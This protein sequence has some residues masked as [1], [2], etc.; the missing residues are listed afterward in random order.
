MFAKRALRPLYLATALTAAVIAAGCSH[1]PQVQEPQRASSLSDAQEQAR[2][3]RDRGQANSQWSFGLGKNKTAESAPE[4]TVPAG[5]IREL[6]EARTFLGTIACPPSDSACM[7]VR[8]LTTMSP[9][10]VWR[11]RASAANTNAEPVISQGCW[12]Q[13]GTNPTRIILQTQNDT[14]LAD[15]SFVHDHQLRVN[16]FNYVKPTLETHL[17]R[18]PEVDSVSELENQTGP[19]CRP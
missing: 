2:G 1:K 6:L 4:Q 14:V 17:S 13:T 18:Q 12:H 15:L 3:G 19:I 16:I 7:P 8:L 9:N 11:M 10:G 5:Q